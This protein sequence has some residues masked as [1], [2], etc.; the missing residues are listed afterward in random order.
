MGYS[1]NIF[2]FARV[3]SL[4]TPALGKIIL[5]YETIEVPG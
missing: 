4:K 1:R 2:I 3:I 5:W